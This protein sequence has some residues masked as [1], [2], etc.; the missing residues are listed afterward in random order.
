MSFQTAGGAQEFPVEG[1]RGQAETQEAIRVNFLHR[2]VWDT[3]IIPEE[4]NLPHPWYPRCGMVVPWKDLNRRHVIATQC[5][6]RSEK[7]RRRLEEEETRESAK[8]S[9][10]AYGGPLVMVTAF[11]YLEVGIR[12]ILDGSGREPL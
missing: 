10:K 4:G 2:H 3:V 11:K 8:I 9:F 1:F 12:E 6:K 5:T 7:K